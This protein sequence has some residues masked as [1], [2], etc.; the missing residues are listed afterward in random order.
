MTKGG[1]DKLSLFLVGSEEGG[2]GKVLDGVC[3]SLRNDKNRNYNRITKT[4]IVDKYI[5]NDSE[6]K[7]TEIKS[8]VRRERINFKFKI[9]KLNK[10]FTY[11]HSSEVCLLSSVQ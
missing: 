10:N 4:Y 9:R 5:G 11:W 1:G 2:G 7:Y 3:G 8:K 6:H